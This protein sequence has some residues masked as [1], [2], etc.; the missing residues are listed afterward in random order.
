MDIHGSTRRPLIYTYVQACTCT[1]MDLRVHAWGY[2]RISMDI[3]VHARMDG[4][5]D[6]MSH[7][8][9]FHSYQVK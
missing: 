7:S 8:T 9:V 4:L 1:S 3:R 6:F 5:I 2:T